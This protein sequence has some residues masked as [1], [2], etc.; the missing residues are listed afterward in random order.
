M[1]NDEVTKKENQ[2]ASFMTWNDFE[3]AIID[4]AIKIK[5]SGKV[6][7]GITGIP[8]GGLIVAVRLSHL[9][10]LPLVEFTADRKVLVCDDITD[11][12]KTLIFYKRTNMPIAVLI[13]KT[14]SKIT[15]DFYSKKIENYIWIEFPW[16]RKVPIN[17]S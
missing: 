15:P 8:R 1:V 14:Q 17:F 4:L 5:K 12:G 7:T 6:F 2:P 10:N 9:L 3:E 16:E 11:I 13:Y